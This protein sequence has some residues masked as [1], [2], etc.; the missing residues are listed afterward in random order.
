MLASLNSDTAVNLSTEEILK[1]R[2]L[3]SYLPSYLSKY[4]SR[5]LTIIP[6]VLWALPS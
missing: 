6:F 3:H 4:S 5:A 2:S 1:K